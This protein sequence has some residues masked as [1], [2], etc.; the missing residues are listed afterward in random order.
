MGT[1]LLASEGVN[2]TIC[3]PRDGMTKLLDWIEAEPRLANLSLKFS[4]PGT[5]ISADESTAKKGNR[6][7]GLPRHQPSENDWHLLNKGL[8]RIDCRPRGHGCRH[9]QQI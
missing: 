3:G 8:E 2:G 5:G 7:H 1:L 9:T 4:T 6:Y